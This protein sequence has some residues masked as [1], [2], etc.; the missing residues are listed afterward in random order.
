MLFEPEKAKDTYT[1]VDEELL[2]SGIESKSPKLTKEYKT[3][4]ANLK[5]LA[6]QTGN[7][8]V[9]KDDWQRSEGMIHRLRLEGLYDKY[10]S[11]GKFQI[12]FNDDY[13]GIP[14]KGFLDCLG[15]GFIVDSKS[16]R[17]MNKF[18]YDV[19]SFSY[20]IQAYIYTKVM[21]IDKFYWL[22]QEKNDPYY[23]GIV[24][25]SDE[26]LFS[27]EMKFYNALENVQA[28]LKGD[29]QIIKGYAEFKV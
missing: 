1:V 28:W 20:D 4:L 14:L 15:D 26:T 29:N 23:P 27:G 9:P 17:S 12:E 7:I 22:V 24:R 25:C 21:G 13:D 3:R 16:T 8:L 5:E 6:K 19:R 2:C 18:K 11:S 10:L